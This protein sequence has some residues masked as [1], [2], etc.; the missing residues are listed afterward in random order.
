MS[1]PRRGPI[2]T[3][4][5]QTL[6]S[7]REVPR[8]DPLVF[9]PALAVALC[10]GFYL[11]LAPASAAGVT[12]RAMAAITHD[13]G[14]LF[15]L[16]AAG[17]LGFAIWLAFGPYG[18]VK[19]GLPE[20]VPE[21]SELS[22][23]A[24]MFSAGIG[25]GLVSWAFV[26]PLYY[27]TGPPLGIEAASS[28]AAEW[29]HMYAMFHWG[30]VPWAMYAVPTVPIAYALYVRGTPFL[31]ISVASEGVLRT[32]ARKRLAPVIDTLVIVGMIGGA[33][34]SLGLAVP[35]VA[36]FA[37]SLTG[38]EDGFGLR[39]AVLG[40]WTALFGTSVYQGL[41]AGIRRLADLNIWLAVI[42]VLFVLLAGPTVFILTLTV[43]SF[44]LMVDN[45]VRMGFWLDPIDAGGF[46]D[47]W[48]LFY[49]AWWIAYAP[50]MALFFGRISRGRTIRRTVLGIMFW[51]P[52][53]CL[54][55]MAVCGGY[56]LHLELT[57]AL[58][59]TEILAEQGNAAT[60]AAIVAALPA[61]QLVT[62]VF[63]VL[64]FVFLA[65]TLD[66]VAYVLASISTRHLPGDEEPDRT[67]RL[68]WAFALAFVAVGL[69]VVDG[70]QTVQAMS[71]ITALP[72][73]PVLGVLVASV[74]VW[75]REDFGAQVRTPVLALRP[76]RSIVELDASSD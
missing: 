32:P 2:S 8:T 53:G 29:A 48:T 30:F 45:F 60:V 24:M 23:A 47:A 70:L 38:V 1:A 9:L 75:L 49:W 55:F 44:G 4:V 3:P 61:G 51:G 28:L 59:V 20:D 27:L 46:P 76:D 12:G 18:Q 6:P 67:L 19:L 72:L 50:L 69:L 42:V 74:L 68:V 34:T 41:K 16:T 17:I 71:V 25:A 13:F 73:V 26:E 10:A 15:V 66:S 35:L 7:T 33:A 39:L 65:T 63:T 57:G 37:S 36:A 5:D 58:P 54:S 56:A 43:N 64:S 31:R 22:W 62:F 40:I 21:Y 11:V 52:L 14:W